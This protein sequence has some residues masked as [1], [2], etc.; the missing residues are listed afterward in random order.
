MVQALSAP[1]IR[2]SDSRMR[3]SGSRVSQQHDLNYRRLSSLPIWHW[4]CQWKSQYTAIPLAIP[5]NLAA[6]YPSQQTHDTSLVK[7]SPLPLGV[8]GLG[9]WGVLKFFLRDSNR[10]SLRLRLSLRYKR[11]IYSSTHWQSVGQPLGRFV[12]CYHA[13]WQ[14]RSFSLS[15]NASFPRPNVRRKRTKKKER[16]EPW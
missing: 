9:A 10:W 15:S 7:P 5:T 14:N 6:D 1:A 4:L 12:F 16:R 8:Q 2:T 3:W 13:D 11:I